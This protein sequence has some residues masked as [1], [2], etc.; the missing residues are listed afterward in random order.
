MC[1]TL[2]VLFVSAPFILYLTDALLT[3]TAGLGAVRWE[4]SPWPL[5][6]LRHRLW[7]TLLDVAVSRLPAPA[8]RVNSR[9]LL[10]DRRRRFQVHLPPVSG[11]DSFADLDG[12]LALFMLRVRIIQLFQANV[13]TRPV[14]SFKTTVQ[15]VVSHAIAIAIA[16][17][18]MQSG[19]DLSRQFVG[20]DLI[21]LL[22]IGAPELI[23]FQDRRKLGVFRRRGGIIGRD[24]GGLLRRRPGGRDN[25]G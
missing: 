23:A 25:K 1:N 7:K 18:L 16:R 12:R 14:S 17:L 15:A 19:R 20:V 8:S 5:G 9:S 2:P 13:A 21:R 22:A 11:N 4:N 10:V 6:R 3:F 24:R